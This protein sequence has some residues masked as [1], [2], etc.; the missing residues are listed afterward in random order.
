MTYIILMAAMGAGAGWLAHRHLDLQMSQ[1]MAIASGALGA[2]LGGLF[3]KAVFSLLFTAIGALIGAAA[4]I[5]LV[6]SVQRRR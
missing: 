3:L 1:G 4:V 2:L 5:F 6:S